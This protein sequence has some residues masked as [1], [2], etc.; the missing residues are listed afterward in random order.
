MQTSLHHT[1]FTPGN[2]RKMRIMRELREH[3][4]DERRNMRRNEGRMR[5]VFIIRL[6]YPLLSN[7]LCY[8]MTPLRSVLASM[9]WSFRWKSVQV[10]MFIWYFFCQLPRAGDLFKKIINCIFPFLFSDLNP[11]ITWT[12][13]HKNWNR[14]RT[15]M[16]LQKW[17][18]L[19]YSIVLC[20]W[21]FHC[22]FMG[23]LSCRV[24]VYAA[25]CCKRVRGEEDDSSSDPTDPGWAATRWAGIYLSASTWLLKTN[26]RGNYCIQNHFSGYLKGK[27]TFAV[28]TNVVRVIFCLGKVC[29]YI[30]ITPNLF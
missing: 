13:C 15:L 18:F 19:K 6:F 21:A 1:S 24:Y 29:N 23:A 14:C 9:H 11:A 3:L 5:A 17:W 28:V 16:S 20:T 7:L 8:I 25:P 26:F 12:S 2:E 4:G 27:K 30:W 10:N 22:D